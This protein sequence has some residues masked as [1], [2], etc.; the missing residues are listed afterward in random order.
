MNTVIELGNMAI[1]FK[2]GV[3]ASTQALVESEAKS[4]MDSISATTTRVVSATKK[5]VES[6]VNRCEKA[7]DCDDERI[8]SPVRA[9][10]LNPHMRFSRV[11]AS[12]IKLRSYEFKRVKEELFNLTGGLNVYIPNNY[13]YWGS[14]SDSFK[15]VAQDVLM[16]KRFGC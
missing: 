9:S 5:V 10:R 13:V 15:L 16:W 3:S 6:F 7:L 1:R 8:V 14:L 4:V 11:E 12:S 2:G